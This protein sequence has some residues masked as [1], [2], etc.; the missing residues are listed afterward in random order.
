MALI[1]CKECG[2]SV[3]NKANICPHCGVDSPDGF[4]EVIGG[5]IF[6]VVIYFIFFN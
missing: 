4:G 5:I 1:S 6:L 2:Q 3:S